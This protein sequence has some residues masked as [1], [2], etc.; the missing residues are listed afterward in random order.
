MPAIRRFRPAVQPRGRQRSKR[1]RPSNGERAGRRGAG[2]QDMQAINWLAGAQT[3]I[4]I[5][6]LA[7]A[8]TYRPA[9]RLAGAQTPPLEPRGLDACTGLLFPIWTDKYVAAARPML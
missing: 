3:S 9:G 7:G 6:R 8:Q 1:G 2:A 4:D 5:D